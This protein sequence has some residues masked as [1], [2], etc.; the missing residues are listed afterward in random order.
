MIA[1]IFTAAILYLPLILVAFLVASGYFKLKGKQI[2]Q[3]DITFMLIM[4]FIGVTL[5]LLATIFM[6]N[7]IS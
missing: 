4:A 3:A 6:V 2:T 7:M 1:L 5:V